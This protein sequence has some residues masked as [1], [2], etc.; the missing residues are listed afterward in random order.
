M[1]KYSMFFFIKQSLSGLFKNGV[2]SLTSI[3]ILMSCLLLMGCF[4]FVI[5]NVNI[6]LDQLNELNKIIF[7]VDENYKAE[8]EFERIKNEIQALDNVKQITVISRREALDQT[9]NKIFESLP[10][11]TLTSDDEF[12]SAVVEANPMPDTIEIE[13]NDIAR[14]DTLMFQLNAI[15]GCG[16]MRNSTDV[17]L[18]IVELKDVVMFVLIWFLIILFVI[19]IFIILNTVKLSVHSRKDEIIIMRYIGATNFFIL[20]P[21]LLEGAIIGFV[22]GILAYFLQWYI[23]GVAVGAI[24]DMQISGL[25]F[26]DFSEVGAAVL[27]IFILVGVL[28]GLLGSSISS[29]RHLKA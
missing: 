29:R 13:Y 7:Y 11:S 27:M 10:D 25:Q 12:Y 21:F 6:N 20:F 15:E 5:L 2:M 14:I 9:W 16:G 23:Y 18:F 22:S 19:A 24:E 3:F 26:I 4:G 8:E 17:A 1:K 28:C